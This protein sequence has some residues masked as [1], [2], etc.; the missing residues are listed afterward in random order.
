VIKLATDAHYPP[1]ESF[2][3]DNV[4]MVGWEPDFWN[5]VAQKLGVKI[6]ATSIAFD[7]LIPAIQSGRFDVAMECMSDT[8]E[9]EVK[10]TFIDVNFSDVGVYTLESN[11]A[12]TSDPESLCGLT[13]ASQRGTTYSDDVDNL[14]SNYCVAHGKKKIGNVALESA[15]ATLLALYAG[16][17]DFVINDI[18]AA[19]E[20]KKHAPKP[21]KLVTI[22]L[23][24]KRYDGMIVR[25][26][27]QQLAEA[28]LAASKAV[29][30]EGVYDLIFA[31][32]DIEAIKLDEFGINLTK[33][34]PLEA[35]Q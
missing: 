19:M 9:R 29:Q 12:I 2:A 4:T 6:E 21:V 32:W 34:R 8:P 5:A 14:L 35:P 25:P 33:T 30:K 28:L 23:F 31:K 20:I 26:D 10:A 22:P 17:V 13:A 18:E 24:P 3:E 7:G 1:C 27:N 16:R 11:A 15:D